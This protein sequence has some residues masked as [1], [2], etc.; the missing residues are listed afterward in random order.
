MYRS[1][2]GSGTGPQAHPD[3]KLPAGVKG[4]FDHFEVDLRVS[5]SLLRGGLPGG[6]GFDLET[7][8]DPDHRWYRKAARVLYRKTSTHL[9]D[10]GEQAM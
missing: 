10:G 1:P 6:P 3:I 5:A 8:N 7:R 2:A 9:R 4:H